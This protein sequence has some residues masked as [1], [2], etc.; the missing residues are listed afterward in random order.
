M[1]DVEATI[2]SHWNQI[3]KIFRNKTFQQHAQGIMPADIIRILH[4]FIIAKYRADVTGNNKQYVKLFLGTVGDDT[5]GNM[6]GARFMEI[7][8]SIDMSAFSKDDKVYQFATNA[9]TIMQKIAN[10]ETLTPKML[11]EITQMMDIGEVTEAVDSVK[12]KD[13]KKSRKKGRKGDDKAAIQEGIQE[14]TE[15]EAEL[16][17]LDAELDI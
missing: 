2:Q 17:M 4:Q 6:D 10:N 1:Y 11:E 3:D 16:K 13:D 15:D 14:I 8:D 9:K 12:D 7:M 5:I